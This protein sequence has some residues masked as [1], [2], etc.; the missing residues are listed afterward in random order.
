MD[1]ITHTLFALTL[2]R[3][4][5]GRAGRGTTAALVLASNAPD[6]DF[7]ATGGGAIT[8]LKW[9]RG[10]T[11]GPLGVIGLG[12]LVAALVVMGQRMWDARR[13]PAPGTRP[14]TFLTL[15]AVSILAVALHVLMDLPTTYGTR[16]LS[17]FD[18][19][20]YSLDWM[21]IIDVYLWIAL[22]A[23]L[24]LGRQTASGRSRNAALA[25]VFMTVN[26]GARAASH[27][28]A[29]EAAPALFG[30][31][32][33]PPCGRAVEPGAMLVRWPIDAAPSSRDVSV[34]CLVDIAA[35]PNFTSPFR[36]RVV[37]QMSNAYE[38]HD[39]DLL[40]RR[41]VDAGGDR[42]AFYRQSIRY[43]NQWTPQVF[44]AARTNLG[45]IYL[46]FS[47]FPAARSVVEPDGFA[48]VRW[49]DMRFVGGALGLDPSR[50][51]DLFTAIVKFAP[52]GTILRQQF[53]P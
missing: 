6:I 45:Q 24:A 31:L 47:R 13:P 20:W 48:T 11:H 23:G 2:G 10:P 9:H 18:W 29:L 42:A 22:G 7:L 52:D 8:Y 19:H 14:A 26:Y 1:N 35:M 53:G 15:A 33:P 36:W 16:L 17:P 12:I 3:T 39:I 30:S 25:L 44:A 41:F 38:I 4:S 37:A 40:D 34:R 27:R 28:Q 32:L 5:L 21:P 43:P 46:G 50:Q 51:T 49:S